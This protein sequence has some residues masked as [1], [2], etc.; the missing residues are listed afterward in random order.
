MTTETNSAG[1]TAVVSAL[2]VATLG[3]FRQFARSKAHDAELMQRLNEHRTTTTGYVVRAAIKAE[4]LANYDA[5]TDAFY[6]EIRTDA[7]GLAG[8][9]GAKRGKDSEDYTVPGGVRQAISEVR[10]ALARGAALVDKDGNPL[11]FNSIKKGNAEAREAAEA[12]KEKAALTPDARER[13][14]IVGILVNV[15]KAVEKAEGAQL[16]IY[17]AGVQAMIA[18]INSAIDRHNK[19]VIA[20]RA[21]ADAAARQ[22]DAATTAPTTTTTTTVAA[23]A[24]AAAA[25]ADAP[26]AAPRPTVTIKGK[27]KRRAA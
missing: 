16:A 17:A 6:S 23:E 12:A 7:N 13:L 21:A 18:H 20:A 24:I 1:V 22:K 9:L 25:P 15:Q 8:L 3:L 14:S 10:T 11:S 4:T 5:A 19:E 26:A 2:V 27:G